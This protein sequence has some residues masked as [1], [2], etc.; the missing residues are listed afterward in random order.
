M[1][2]NITDITQYC[3]L[4]CCWSNPETLLDITQVLPILL[5]IANL[6]ILHNITNITQYYELNIDQ[7]YPILRF[8][9]YSIFHWWYSVSMLLNITNNNCWSNITEYYLFNI[10]QYS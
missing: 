4:E 9:C 3:I 6:P 5:N 1:L 2:L 10:T 7:Y 8:Q